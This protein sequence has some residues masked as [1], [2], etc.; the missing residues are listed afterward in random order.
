MSLP[1]ELLARIE[2]RR[3]DRK[4]SRS[5]VVSELLWRGWRLVEAEEREERYRSA[6]KEQPETGAERSWAEAAAKDFFGENDIGWS[7]D[8]QATGAAS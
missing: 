6:Y 8:D 1:S 7:D 2:R 5:E 4:A 3:H